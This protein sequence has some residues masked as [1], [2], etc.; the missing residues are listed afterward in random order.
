MHLKVLSDSLCYFLHS[1]AN[2]PKKMNKII[3]LGKINYIKYN[4]MEKSILFK[5]E[6]KP[7]KKKDKCNTWHLTSS[8]WSDM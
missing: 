7:L 6:N 2:C 3:L 1:F 4:F 5:K 8:L